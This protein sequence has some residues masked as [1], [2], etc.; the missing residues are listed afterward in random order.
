MDHDNDG[1]ITSGTLLSQQRFQAFAGRAEGPEGI[2]EPDAPVD[3]ENDPAAILARTP[4]ESGF[5]N[6]RL[7]LNSPMSFLYLKVSASTLASVKR[8][9]R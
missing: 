6:P 3:A 9:S 7:A 8:A 4:A 2:T 5:D 1:L